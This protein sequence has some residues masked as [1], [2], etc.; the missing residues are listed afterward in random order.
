[1]LVVE[2]VAA[3]SRPDLSGGVDTGERSSCAGEADCAFFGPPKE[4]VRPADLRKLLDADFGIE[5]TGLPL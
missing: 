3:R 5:G 4:K 2:E 1:M